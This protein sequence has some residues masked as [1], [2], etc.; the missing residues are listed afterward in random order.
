MKA[1]IYAR[2]S[3][4]GQRENFSIPTQVEACVKFCQ[5]K[6]YDIVG[7]HYVDPETGLDREPGADA[8]P[9]FVD[10]FTSR[11]IS[12]PGINAMFSYLENTEVGIVVVH[13]IDRLARDLYLRMTIERDLKAQRIQVE[14]VLGNYD[15]SPEGEVRKDMEAVF[16][17][18]E[19]AKRVERSNRGKRKKAE[20]GQFVGGRTP[21]G[22]TIDRE[23]LGGLAVVEEEAE[24]VRMVFDW[25]V[26][27]EE[28]IRG[29]TRRLNKR[30]VQTSMGNGKWYKSS[31]YKVLNNTAYNGYLYYNKTKRVGN[32][33]IDRDPS[34]WIKIDVTPIVD[35][36][37]FAQVQKELE[38]NKSARRRRTDRFYLLSGRIKCDLCKH[39]YS[40]ETQ[41]AGKQRRKHDAQYYRH[42]K[43]HGHCKNRYISARILEPVVW[44]EV[45]NILLDPSYLK[46]GYE[47]AFQLETRQHQADRKKLEDLNQ[48]LEIL[49]SK[50]EQIIEIFIDPDLPMSREEYINKKESL[51][52]RKQDILD[53]ITNLQQQISNFSPPPAIETMEQ[54]TKEIGQRLDGSS[55]FPKRKKREILDLLDIEI[56]IEE[57]DSFRLTGRITP[58]DNRLAFSPHS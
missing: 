34:E 4:S 52:D 58:P 46:Q 18:W 45:K 36:H 13:S 50:S 29:I 44:G 43:T 16:A 35:E 3:T 2:V 24:V 49:E 8:I 26:N 31:V 14:Y 23:V 12:R 9:A 54:F 37:K 17:K 47:E 28:S 6:G 53:A 38:R 25:Y 27:E 15:Q 5:Q 19:N 42:R 40:G 22:Y 57:G 41:K 30:G 20:A 33:R 56:W 11:E 55:K 7:D 51:K 1:V 32:E 48:E 39:V 21:Y 10:N